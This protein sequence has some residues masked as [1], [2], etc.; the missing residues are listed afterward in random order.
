VKTNTNNASQSTLVPQDKLVQPR[1]FKRWRF[2]RIFLWFI[3]SILHIYFYDILLTRWTLTRW[4][5]QQTSVR[6]WAKMARNF[7]SMAVQLGGVLIKLGQFLSIRAD[8]FPEQ[9]LQELAGLQDEVPPVDYRYIEAIILADLGKKPD[10]VFAE[11]EQ[12]PMAAASFGQVHY[13]T[14]HNGQKLAVKVQR[15]RIDEILE[16]DL[17]A[18]SWAVQLIKNYPLIR[19]RANLEALFEEFGRVLR[20]ELDYRQEARNA[21]EFRRNMASIPGVIVPTSYPE[22]TTKRVLTMERVSG[23][24]INDLQAIEREHIDRKV[25]AS[26]FYRAYLQQW[27]V[28]GFFHA[29]PHPGNLLLRVNT[30]GTS[31][32]PTSDFSLIFLDFGMVGRI[33]PHMREVLRSLMIALAGNDAYAFVDALERLDVFLPGANRREIVRAIELMFHHVYER[34]LS[35]ISNF[36]EIEGIVEEM[37]DLIWSMPFQIPQDLIYVGRSVSMVAGMATMLDPKMNLFDTLKPFVQTVIIGDRGVGDTVELLREN[38]GEML[39]VAATLP[40]EMYG[41]Y[42]QANRGELRIKPDYAKLERHLRRI[43]VRSQQIHQTILT[44]SLGLGG[45]LFYI[46]QFTQEAYWA[47][48]IAAVL[49]LWSVRPRFDK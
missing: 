3:G 48:G 40:K 21:I 28:D 29:D 17:S 24:K 46:N 4:I 18:V 34:N 33:A 6:R 38:A 1:I 35:Q 41:F 11:F 15:P 9:I 45:V 49:Y 5:S 25:L 22:L 42:Q 47:W 27:F 32:K 19:R 13:A 8:I 44:A 39:K 26:R 31:S 14:M 30:P 7:R 37:G 36:D 23:L 20:E 16:V 10:Q 43:E 12:T 2:F